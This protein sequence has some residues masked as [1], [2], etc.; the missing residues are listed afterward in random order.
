MKKL[1][2]G[3]L[4]ALAKYEPLYLVFSFPHLIAASSLTLAGVYFPKVFIGQLERSESFQKIAVSIATYI[5]LLIA[6]KCFD[7]FFVYK[8]DVYRERFKKNIRCLA[9]ELTM[10]Q[11]LSEIEGTGFADKLTMSGKVTQLTDAFAVFLNIATDLITI[12]GLSFMISLLDFAFLL[13]IAVVVGMKLIFVCLTQRYQKKRR[14]LYAANDRIGNYLDSTAY[15]SPGAAKELRINSLGGWYMDKI[16]GFRERMLTL[17]YGDFN[18]Y[19]AIN[20]LSGL[21]LALQSLVIQ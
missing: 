9:G 18:R 2:S 16:K 19:A 8:A 20:V 21:I 10:A 13:T 1:S 15:T 17:Q 3:I 12:A 11:P 14:L 4:S 6:L 5:L 7:A